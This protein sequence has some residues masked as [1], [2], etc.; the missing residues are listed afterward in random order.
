MGLTQEY[1][2]KIEKRLREL[3]T[4][5]EELNEKANSEVKTDYNE[6]LQPIREQMN[7]AFS[8]ANEVLNSSLKEW[9]KKIEELTDKS[10]SEAREEYNEVINKIQSKI[11]DLKGEM[12]KMRG[13][14]NEAWAEIKTGAETA[15]NDLKHS[16]SNALSKLK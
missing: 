7:D 5:I 11:D 15:W 12:D 1:L 6:K 8:K 2:E 16:F 3:G 10:K 14:G 9:G 13:S 4:K